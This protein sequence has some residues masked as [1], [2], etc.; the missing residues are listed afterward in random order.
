M[1]LMSLHVT[2]TVPLRG[3]VWMAS[4][5]PS[6]GG[7]IQKIRPAVVMSNDTANALHNRVQLVPV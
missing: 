4:F 2:D 7:E 5:D 3:E 6:L 1:L